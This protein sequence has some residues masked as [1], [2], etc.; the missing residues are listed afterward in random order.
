M[1][2]WSTAALDVK[3][4]ATWHFPEAIEICAAIEILEAGNTPEVLAGIQSS[5]AKHVRPLLVR[6]LFGSVLLKTVRAY[7]PNPRPGDRHLRVAF[8][9]LTDPAVRGEVAARGDATALSSAV[10]RWDICC[11]DHR[12]ETL[13]HTRDK[14]LAHLGEKTKPSPLI[15]DLLVLRARRRA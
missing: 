15:S 10:Q 12:L 14:D 5:S 8:D 6:M 13:R 11:G 9:L 3:E 4:I 2:G 1:K 7:A